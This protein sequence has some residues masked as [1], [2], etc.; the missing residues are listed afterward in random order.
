MTIDKTLSDFNADEL[1][2]VEIVLELEDELKLEMATHEAAG[3]PATE[4]FERIEVKPK[5]TNV[6]VKLV[7]LLWT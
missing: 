2:L 6:S 4:T 1:D 7:A 3:D 5:R